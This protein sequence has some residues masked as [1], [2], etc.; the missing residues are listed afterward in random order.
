[1]LEELRDD[2]F[3]VDA[4]CLGLEV[5]E[6]A[7]PQHGWRDRADVVERDGWPA[8]QHGSRLAGQEQ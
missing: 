1:V 6:Q 8:M 4:F 3:G 5:Y 7:V 2:G